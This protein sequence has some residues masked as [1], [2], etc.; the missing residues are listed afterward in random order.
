MQSTFYPAILESIRIDQDL[1]CDKIA[2]FAYTMAD[3]M[4]AVREASNGS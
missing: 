2:E 3:A 4:I 1:N